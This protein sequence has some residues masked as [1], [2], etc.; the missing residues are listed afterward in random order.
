VLAYLGRAPNSK[1]TADYEAAAAA[2][3]QVRPTIRKFHSSESINALAN[4]DICIAVGYSGDMLQARNRAL[5]AKRG[6]KINYVIPQEGAQIW[7]D[8]M[9]VPSD[10][11]NVANAHAFINYMMRPEVIAKA[12]NFVSY[13]NGNLASQ[14][15]VDPKILK[16]PAIYPNDAIMQKLFAITPHDAKMQRFVTR[17]WTRVKSGR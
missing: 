17:Q 9:V 4:G 1:A 10:A 12:S 7:F 8:M 5:E 3:A 15:F 2:L 14:K 11:P 16:D 6:V 13:A